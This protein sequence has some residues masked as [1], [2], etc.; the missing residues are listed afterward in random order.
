VQFLGV[1]RPFRV[2]GGMLTFLPLM[3]TEHEW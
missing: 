1:F 3:R 2:S